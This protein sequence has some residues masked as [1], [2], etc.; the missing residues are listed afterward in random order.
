M[1]EFVVELTPLARFHL[2]PRFTAY[3]GPFKSQTESKAFRTAYG[4]LGLLPIQRAAERSNG[5][6]SAKQASSVEP[7]AFVLTFDEVQVLREVANSKPKD[8]ALELVLGPVVDD[9]DAVMDGKPRAS[10]AHPF[11]GDEDWAP[12]KA[13][14]AQ[15]E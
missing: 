6:L 2:L 15:P 11:D 3:P 13:K 14:D 8:G 7:A 10:L 4:K 1:D 12:P 9:L 5:Q